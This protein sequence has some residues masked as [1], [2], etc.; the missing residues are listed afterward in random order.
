VVADGDLTGKQRNK[1]LDS[2]TDEVAALVLDDNY[3]Q[4]VA[5]ANA[6]E[7]AP[8]LLH[9]HADWIKRLVKMGKLDPELEF[10]PSQK[11]IAQRRAD[12]EG[13]TAPEMSVL[14]AY[15]KIVLTEQLLESVLSDDPLLRGLLYRYFPTGMRQDYRGWMDEHPLRRQIVVTQIVNNLVNGA[16]I[17]FYHR[18]SGETGAHAAELARAH[19]IAQEIFA[20]PSLTQQ[21]NALD[22]QIDARVQTQMRL[23]ARTLAERV[24]RWLINN[25]R[26]TD[27]SE[28]VDYFDPMAQQVVRALPDVLVGREAEA[29]RQRVEHL[30]SAGVSP[31][32]A[33]QV[34]SMPPAYMALGIV[35]IARTESLDPL[36]VARVHF[37]L[38]DHLG[39]DRL[40]E[41]ILALPRDDRWRTMARATLR[42]DLHA[43]H[44]QLTSRVLATTSPD[45]PPVARIATWSETEGPVL[46][47]AMTTL[48]EIWSEDT[49]DLARLSVGLR[50]V[51][52]LLSG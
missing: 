38:S 24:T 28:S 13:L 26:H 18:L 23:A 11:E 27:A 32:L 39:L 30:E 16:G 2:M 29:L 40:T 43:V 49:P 41:R 35:D 46:E 9:V 10:L 21:I 19:A 7:Q 12:G 48:E 4:N 1:L 45:D 15:T 42:D 34:A 31:E 47:R 22:N 44:A 3:Q 36:E 50:V 17:T 5:L 20:T 25:R 33:M 51:R 52:S 14:L 6:L 8:A 37:G